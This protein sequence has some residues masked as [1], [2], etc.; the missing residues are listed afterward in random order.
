MKKLVISLMIILISISPLFRG[1][2]FSYETYGFMAVL[3]LL[4][5]LYF[6]IA[7]A[8]HETVRLNKLYLIAGILMLAGI[9]FSFANAMNIR[10][11]LESLFFHMELLVLFIVLYDYFYG[12]KLQF[13]RAVMLPA[14]VVG[15]VAGFVGMVALT[16]KF[17]VWHVTTLSN[18]VGST[19]QYANTAS[20]YFLICY[21]F[22]ITLANTFE[23]WYTGPL[24]VGLGSVSLFAFFMTGSRGGFLT[25]ILMLP[26]LVAIQPSGLRVRTL[27]AMASSA[28]SVFGVMKR[29]NS[30]V[31]AKDNFEAAKWIVLSFV[32]AAAVYSAAGAVVKAV[33]ERIQFNLSKRA[34]ILTAAAVVLVLFIALVNW[35]SLIRLFPPVMARRLELLYSMGL[36]DKNVQFRLEFDRDAIKLL[37]SHWLFGLGGDG[38]KALYQSVQDFG[39]TANYVHNHYLQIFVDHG[40]LT[41]LSYTGLVVISAA[42]FIYSYLKTKDKL[43]RACTA[44]MLCGFIALAVHSSFDFDLS[45]ASVALL[46]WGMFAVSATEGRDRWK[47]GLSSDIGKLALV[48]ACSLLFS[49]FAIY[50]TA[51]FNGQKAQDFMQKKDYRYAMQYYE[52]AVRLDP[53]NAAYTF[54]L[55]KI[56]HYYGKSTRDGEVRAR[57]LEKARKAGEI[58]VNGNKCYPAY[59][60]TLV[61]IYLDSGMPVEA[62][63]MAQ[64]LLLYQRYNAEVYELLA[65]S[66]IDAAV[67]YEKNGDTARAKELVARCISIDDDPN[68]RRSVIERPNEVGSPEVVARYRHS[69]KLAGYL[70]E[71]EEYFGKLK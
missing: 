49:M 69:E 25:G 40:I 10:A 45:F 56:Y 13:M 15:A 11:T 47:A 62:L 64:D 60:K 34:K 38:W 59:M 52:N 8:R 5:I 1:L 16:G 21:I 18:R 36:K 19:F 42:S 27:V 7:I 65:R 70:K 37:K 68:L 6:F 26:V 61:G 46:F 57:W 58:S 2:F 32:I 22:A 41:F 48:A 30:A 55:A 43:L 39:Y 17:N 63:E 20:V 23:M 53:S 50:F 28:A 66:Y 4:C 31:A 35:E 51:A 54:E 33:S 14:V 12:R 67:H 24:I 3:A 71:A 44:G 9:C 29:F